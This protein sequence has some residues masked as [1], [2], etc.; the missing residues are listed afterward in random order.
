MS[1]FHRECVFHCAHGGNVQ[2]EYI[3]MYVCHSFR[4]FSQFLLLCD[5]TT[6]SELQELICHLRLVVPF[7]YSK[8][9]SPQLFQEVQ[10]PTGQ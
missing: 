6:F 1:G 8:L 3:H 4:N 9:K 5:K 2:I 7:C 10:Y